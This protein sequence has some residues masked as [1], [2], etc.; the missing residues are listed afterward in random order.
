MFNNSFKRFN[1]EKAPMVDYTLETFP[2]HHNKI[3][4]LKTL[5]EL[6]I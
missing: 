2:T 1:Q 3:K 6:Q 4:R 5:Q